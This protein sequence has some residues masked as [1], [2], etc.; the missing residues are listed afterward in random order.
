VRIAALDIG[1]KRIG[2]AVSD[3]GG[4]VAT[5][6]KVLDAAVLRDPGPLLRLLEEYGIGLVVVGLPLSLDGTEGPQARAV[7]A[8]VARL[9][10][11]L[12]VP[13]EFADERL[14]SAQARRALGD[15]GLSDRAKRGRIDMAAASLFLQSYLDARRASQAREGADDS[16]E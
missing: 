12:G 4:R 3:P 1:E 6:L 8:S 5:P 16:Q 11:A 15:A 7:R 10:P 13:V 9:G 14:S 2:V